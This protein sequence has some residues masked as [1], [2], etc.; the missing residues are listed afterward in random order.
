MNNLS[1]IPF[2]PH[3]RSRAINADPHQKSVRCRR[4]LLRILPASNAFLMFILCYLV[5]KVP[6]NPLPKLA[7]KFPPNFLPNL[8]PTVPP[9]ALPTS[10]P[11]VPAAV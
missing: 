5:N 8:P 7:P 11:T 3:G 1:N 6:N 9:I 4:I 2:L 10:R